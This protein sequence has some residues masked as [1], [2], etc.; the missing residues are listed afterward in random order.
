V[1]YLH[2]NIKQIY[3]ERQLT[4]ARLEAEV[5]THAKRYMEVVSSGTGPDLHDE[6]MPPAKRRRLNSSL[7]D[8]SSNAVAKSRPVKYERH[9]RPPALWKELRALEQKR[10][11]NESLELEKTE[12]VVPVAASA[13]PSSSEPLPEAL[14][15]RSRNAWCQRWRDMV[16][17]G[18]D[19]VNTKQSNGV[20]LQV[21][22]PTTGHETGDF[23]QVEDYTCPSCCNS[24]PTL[25]A[26]S[27][28]EEEVERWRPRPVED[29]DNY[30]VYQ[31]N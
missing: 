13:A 1:K 25:S 4:D 29:F 10:R 12:R 15:P 28:T 31:W 2:I 19:N 20:T 23:V 21:Y 5:Q 3:S 8:G 18:E 16:A 30:P 27:L 11:D 22:D 26:C 6:D 9:R 24:S 14:I 7:D 17:M